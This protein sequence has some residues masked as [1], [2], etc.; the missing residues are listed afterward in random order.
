M[1]IAISVINSE[2]RS[3]NGTCLSETTHP[4]K[5][6]NISPTSIAKYIIGSV[7]KFNFV[8]TCLGVIF[9]TYL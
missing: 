2:I 5:Q 8:I 6:L 1:F 4:S 7:Q 9:F 3:V